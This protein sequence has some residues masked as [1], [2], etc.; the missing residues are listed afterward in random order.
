MRRTG[1]GAARAT[2]YRAD[3]AAAHGPLNTLIRTRVNTVIIIDNWDDLLRIAGSLLTGGS[4][5]PNCSAT[6]LAAAAP[7]RLAGR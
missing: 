2:L 6:S 5:P 3:P 4:A 1:D 7:P